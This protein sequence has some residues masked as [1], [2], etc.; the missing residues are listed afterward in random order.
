MPD[1]MQ[2]LQGNDLEFLRM[3]ANAWGLELVQPDAASALPVLVDSLKDAALLDEVLDVLPQEALEG[4]QLL[5]EN[6]GKMLWAAFCR[7]FGEVRPMG[8][9]KRDRERP[10]LKPSS[11]TEVLWYRA[12]IAKAFL[13]LPP[14]PQ[15]Y[16]FIPDDLAPLMAHLAPAPATAPDKPFGQP[17]SADE[18]ALIIPANDRILDHAC[19]LLAAIRSGI[20]LD[21]L[22][23]RWPI[24]TSI[25]ISLLY[26][27]GLVDAS[28]QIQTEAVRSFLEASR[29]EALLQLS[30]GWLQSETFNDLRCLP[31][32]TF[33]GQ[34]DNRPRQARSFLMD[35][36]SRLPQESWWSLSSLVSAIREKMPDYQRPG[37]DY[38]TWFIR[39]EGSDTFL[40]GFAAWDEVDGALIRFVLTSPLHWLGWVDLASP[41]PDQPV[42]AFRPSAWAGALRQNVPPSGLPDENHS[43]KIMPDGRLR[44]PALAARSVR[45]QIARFC[46]WE[47]ELPAEYRF[48]LT[49]AS[50]ERAREQGLRASHLLVLLKRSTSGS[51]PPVLVQALERWEKFGVQ[52]VLEPA[53]LLRLAAPEM[54]AA[55]RKSRA[56]RYLGE[57][58][59]PTV[60]AIKPGGEEAV[61]QALGDLGYLTED[62]QL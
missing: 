36:F 12:L 44:V 26:S 62:H 45:Y 4:I 34:W 39:K 13:N 18:T 10:D 11:V 50:L 8:P 43:I 28:L 5:L 40:R 2:A 38:D 24:P 51:I 17:A 14:E 16:A 60:I 22:E 53:V 15:E 47:S 46:E 6:D 37:G 52:A 58:L 48:R 54:L 41:A 29:G 1:L 32:L 25:L 33:E 56:G 7:K 3:V 9:G 19:T 59:S 30:Q 35:V 31:G 57:A 49:P 61:R 23:N 27:A 21:L 42:S 55:L 20:N